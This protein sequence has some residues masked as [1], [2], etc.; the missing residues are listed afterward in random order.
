MRKQIVLLILLMMAASAFAEG[1]DSQ[2]WKSLSTVESSLDSKPN[3]QGGILSDL[4][5]R[6]LELPIVADSCVSDQEGDAIK[7]DPKA[8]IDLIGMCAG[9]N[10]RKI[11][12]VQKYSAKST[13]EKIGGFIY[14]DI[15]QDPSTGQKPPMFEALPNLR[16]IGYE[17][18]ISLFDIP[19]ALAHGYDPFARVFDNSGNAY[20]FP[21]SVDFA[22]HTIIIEIDLELLKDDGNMN[23]ATIVGNQEGPTDIAPDGSSYGDVLRLLEARADIFPGSTKFLETQSFELGIMV[24]TGNSSLMAM[25]QT[26]VNGRP[27][28]FLQTRG[29]RTDISSRRNTTIYVVPGFQQMLRPGKN[30]ITVG[31]ITTRGIFGDE[32]EIKIVPTKLPTAVPFPTPIPPP[33]P[34]LP[35][36]P[37]SPGN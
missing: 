7:Q 32:I 36:P 8:V 5:H 19:E 12:I 23:I 30:I 10:G 11:Q 33:P 6:D 16:G 31:L 28:N 14:L 3:G 20:Y 13:L 1:N 22:A 29:V 35:P 18:T 24:E 15:D 34:P 21:A 26:F 25:P 9:T 27:V 2:G 4:R 37:P 17:Y